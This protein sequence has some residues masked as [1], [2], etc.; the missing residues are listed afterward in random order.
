MYNIKIQKW[1]TFSYTSYEQLS[2]EIFT[3]TS[4]GIALKK[5]RYKFNTICTELYVGIA[6]LM[7]EMKELSKWGNILCK[8]TELEDSIL[9]GCQFFP[10]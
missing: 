9:F 7:K 6:T 2:C 10:T 4:L 3:K 8:C 5:I 1:I